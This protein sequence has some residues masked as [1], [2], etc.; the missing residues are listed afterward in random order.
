MPNGALFE[1][2]ADR[3]PPAP[4]PRIC[5]AKLTG[6]KRAVGAGTGN[7]DVIDQREIPREPR[8]RLAWWT[9]L[10]EELTPADKTKADDRSRRTVTGF[11]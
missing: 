1:G 11:V 9:L 7:H 2:S 5:E 6:E 10:A 3:L 4:T 8:V